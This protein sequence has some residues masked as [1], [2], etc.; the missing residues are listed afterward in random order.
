MSASNFWYY[1]QRLAQFHC[2][3]GAQAVDDTQQRRR[4]AHI[5]QIGACGDILCTVLIN[6]GDNTYCTVLH[7]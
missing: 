1:G 6:D 7:G 5:G 4:S 2:E 3:N